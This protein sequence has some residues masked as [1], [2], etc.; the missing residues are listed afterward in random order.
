[1]ASQATLRYWT[2]IKAAAERHGLDPTLL[3]GVVD[4]ESGGDPSIRNKS[5]GATGLGQVMPR[6]AG[7]SFRDRPTAEALKDPDTN[8]EWAARILKSGLDRYGTED[9]ALAAYLGSI[10]ARGNITGAV[11]AN[12]TGGN[13]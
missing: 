4:F 5:S 10:D 13:Q 9:K 2:K 1:M 7:A 3:L 12:G 8:L 6:E 11:D